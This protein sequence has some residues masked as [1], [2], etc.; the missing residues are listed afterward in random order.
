MK[1]TLK[2]IADYVGGRIVGDENI[3]ISGLDNIEGAGEHDLTF[4]VEPHI[5]EAKST[6]AAAVM[7]PEGIEDFPRPALY[8][9]EP[10]AAFASLLALFT[11]K[12]VFP[13][14]VSSEAHIGKDVKLGED[15]TVLPFACVDD[16]AVIEIGRAHV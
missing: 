7:L 12:L 6:R 1:K 16:H 5:E 2:E 4:A 13:K 9:A 15:V 11:P 3:V 10:R 8:V 14:G